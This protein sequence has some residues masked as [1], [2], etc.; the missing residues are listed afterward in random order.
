MNLLPLDLLHGLVDE[1]LEV[2][3][4]FDAEV[5][6][7]KVTFA[8]VTLEDYET[9]LVHERGVEKLATTQLSDDL[10]HW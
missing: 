4:F 8:D 5:R 1:V 2:L 10:T 6:W 9:G 7:S 3:Q